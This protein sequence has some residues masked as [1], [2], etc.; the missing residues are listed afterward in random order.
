MKQQEA[1]EIILTEKYQPYL[2]TLDDM[3]VEFKAKLGI[4][5]EEPKE[6][7]KEEDRPKTSNQT[8]KNI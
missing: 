5:E 7:E 2:N 6:Q 4:Q 8:T 3:E 1:R